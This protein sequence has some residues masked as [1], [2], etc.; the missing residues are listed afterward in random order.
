M[1]VFVEQNRVVCGFKNSDSWVILSEIEQRIK[2]KIEA[3]GIPLRNWDVH[4]NYGIKTSCTEAFVINTKKRNEI[5]ASCKSE[6][7]RRRTEK[8]IQPVLRG[9]DIRRY[10]Y[11]WAGLW[12]INSHNGI[13]A[14]YPRVKIE[15]YPAVK[16][17][18]DR[19]GVAYNGKLYEGYG[20][21]KKR[22]DQGDTPYNLRNC[23]YLEDFF[24]P[25]IVY[26]EIQTD[27]PQEGYYFPCFSYDESN[28][29]VLNTAY[30]MCSDTIDVRYIL[31]ILNSSLGAILA[32][33]YITQ[34]QKRQFR[35]LAQYVCNFPIVKAQADQMNK[36][37]KLVEKQLASPSFE[38]EKKINELVFSL[39]EINGR[40][41]DFI[42]DQ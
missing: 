12:L 40:E 19:G 7:E 3:I 27:N 25:K 1:S 42:L 39:Y 22:E 6:E 10:G 23:A 20:R 5:L 29:Y 11:D 17:W 31:G 36:L 33:F 35:M 26:M 32:K 30:I 37:V 2:Q 14:K 24:K 4:I 28:T 21:I 15:E 16:K 18:L 38:T 41:K 34:L 9:R 13:N 8:L